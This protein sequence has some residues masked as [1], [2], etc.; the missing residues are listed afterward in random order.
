MRTTVTGKKIARHAHWEDVQP[1]ISCHST[2][3]RMESRPTDWFED[4]ASESPFV[5][6]VSEHHSCRDSQLG[7]KRHEIPRRDSTRPGGPRG[8]TRPSAFI[9]CSIHVSSLFFSPPVAWPILL[10]QRLYESVCTA[11][12]RESWWSTSSTRPTDRS[13]VYKRCSVM[14]GRW[15]NQWPARIRPIQP[16]CRLSP[17]DSQRRSIAP[18]HGP[19]LSHPTV[20][21]WSVMHRN[22]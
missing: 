15:S 14:D 4:P 12:T 19:H 1:Y 2:T 16:S 22:G 18:C 13:L 10:G 3:G 20:C 7:E 9:C 5:A 17:E 21:A 11:H 6:R 8:Q